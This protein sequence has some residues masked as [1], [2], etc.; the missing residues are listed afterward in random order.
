MVEVMLC[1]ELEKAGMKTE[2]NGGEEQESRKKKR[3][4]R[5]VSSKTV[6]LPSTPRHREGMA[7][8]NSSAREDEQ[9]QG[10]GR[11]LA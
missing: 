4:S 6:V 5:D 11:R 8:L 7:E 2:P 10:P 1:P 3:A 9:K